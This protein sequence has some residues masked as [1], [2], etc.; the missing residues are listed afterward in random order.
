V[1]R[2]QPAPLG[3][4]S[5]SGASVDLYWLPLGAG[6]HSVRLNGKVFEAVAS[7]L[8]GRRA[9]DLYHSAL[10]VHVPGGQFVIEQAP[11]QRGDGAKRGV[12]SEG[13]VGSRWAGRF[14]IFRYELRRWRDGVIPDVDEAVESPRRLT[15]DPYL[16]RRILDLV[17]QLPT[18]VWGRDELRTGEMWNSNSF[19]AWLLARSGLSTDAIRPPAGGRAPGWN[20]GVVVARRQRADATDGALVAPFDSLAARTEIASRAVGQ[21][22]PLEAGR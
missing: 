2:V 15:D 14:R 11:A 9:C 18:P 7:R 22:Q 17:S 19:I 12:V 6:G 16:A 1:T 3:Y 5:P 13:A 20:A 21:S 4:R 8:A 10:V